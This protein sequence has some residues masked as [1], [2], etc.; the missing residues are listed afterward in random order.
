MLARLPAVPIRPTLE[1]DATAHTLRGPLL[2]AVVEAAGVAPRASVMLALRALDGYPVA[3]SSADAPEAFGVQ[4]LPNENDQHLACVA[5]N[6][7][8]SS[9]PVWR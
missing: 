4:H 3:V 8:R 1:Y 5:T 2:G 9:F 7:R 6:Q